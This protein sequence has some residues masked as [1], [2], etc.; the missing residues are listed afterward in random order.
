[1][2]NFFLTCKE[3]ILE[4]PRKFYGAFYLGPFNNS[5]SLTIANGLRRTLLSEIAGLGI[6]MVEIEG[7]EHEFC[8]Y[9]GLRESILDFLL[10]FKEIVLVSNLQNKT[11]L[12][13]KKQFKKLNLKNFK[14][15]SKNFNQKPLYGY[16]QAKGPG[17]IRASDLKL[18]ASIG[19]NFIF[20]YGI[21]G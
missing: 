6:E 8:T 11:K 1:M 7:V 21:N 12:R 3:C 2:K 13:E 20:N 5:Q 17:I 9:P 14:N 10:N 16:L 15:S 19:Y 18:P 4:N